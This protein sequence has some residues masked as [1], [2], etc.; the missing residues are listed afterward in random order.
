MARTSFENS[1]AHPLM[2]SASPP[3]LLSRVHPALPMRPE[4]GPLPGQDQ[5]DEWGE[6]RLTDLIER[7]Q[8]SIEYYDDANQRAILA[9]DYY[10]GKQLTDEEASELRRR[11]QAP[12]VKNRIRRKIDFLQGMER[13]QRTDPKA[14]P[15]RPSQRDDSDAATIAIRSV[16]ASNK[17]DQIR[18]HVWADML[19]VGWGGVECVLEPAKNQNLNPRVVL[20]HCKW[21]RMFWDEYSDELDF[22]DAGHL[23][24][25]IWMDRD[26]AVR[27][28]GERASDVY[29]ET[30]ASQSTTTLYD[31]KPAWGHWVDTSRRKRIRVVQMYFL[32]GVSGQWLFAEFTKGG[33]LKYGPSP[34]V[35]EDGESE[36]GY[37][38]R[39]C[40]IDRENNRYGIIK[41]M[42]DVQDAV[43]KRESK[44]LHLASVRQTFANEGSLGSMTTREMRL[45]LAK[46]DGHVDL[47]PG[48]KFGE[49]FGV[50]PTGDQFTAQIELLKNDMNEL[51]LMGP[52]AS[53]QGKGPQDQSGRAILAQQQGGQMEV[54]P[55]LDTLRDLDRETYE[56]I[57]KR[58]RQGWTGPEWIRVSDDQKN[59]RF[60]GLNKPAMQ[61][62]IIPGT[63]QPVMDPQTGQPM[64]QP[65]IDPMTGRPKIEQNDIATLGVD[66]TIEDAPK[67]GQL[68]I[69]SFQTIAELAKMVPS[70]AQMPAEAWLKL[71]GID[72]Y[73]EVI[74]MIAAQQQQA[75]QQPPNPAQQLQVAGAQAEIQKKQGQA[76]NE[77]ATA[78]H[79][80]AMA[81]QLRVQT[82]HEALKAAHGHAD[83]LTKAARG[84]LDPH[85]MIPSAEHVIPPGTHT[86]PSAE[87]LMPSAEH[88]IPP[89]ENPQ[90][91]P[92]L[93]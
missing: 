61:P 45:Q 38:W 54:G 23:G 53:M 32:D 36:H 47:A 31:D 48:K 34:W 59:I 58:I 26:E 7:F 86:T 41:D 70:L 40:Y 15:Q 89:A 44:A 33:F 3:A 17:F 37:I 83:H 71:S 14:Q 68:R 80:I 27:R 66:I 8:S 46:P 20:R 30:V 62:L 25:V 1:L 92:G 69:E 84:G 2:N 24:L 9:M 57:W 88:L 67:M 72:N 87:H 63:N 39:S 18:S 79:K 56:K 22:S 4:P 49:D 16:T 29:D 21:D 76:I 64:M 65:V 77:Q 12:V 35:N 55:H 93:E 51:D 50:I 11:G 28:Y 52:N 73:A 60:V 81:N 6:D 43:N 75:A 82:A 19:R 85:H 13:A 42:I 91:Q 74:T 5:N 78:E 90:S 10:D